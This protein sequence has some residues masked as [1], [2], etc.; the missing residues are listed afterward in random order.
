MARSSRA[1]TEAARA[2]ESASLLAARGAGSAGKAL[3]APS[4]QQGIGAREKYSARPAPSSTTLGRP[5][6]MFW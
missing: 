4:R 5:S 1:R 6:Q 2:R 3:A